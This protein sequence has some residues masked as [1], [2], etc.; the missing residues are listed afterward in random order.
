MPSLKMSFWIYDFIDEL[1]YAI[2]TEIVSEMKE[3]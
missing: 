2:C 3:V 1:L